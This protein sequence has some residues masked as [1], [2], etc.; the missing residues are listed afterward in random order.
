M[1][2][3]KGY[4]SDKNMK[5][6]YPG[7]EQPPRGVKLALLTIGNIQTTGTW[8]DSYCKAWQRL[9]TRDKA[10]EREHDIK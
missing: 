4:A 3:A 6:I 5:W 7:Q 1:T 10:Y 2:D 8:D 9:F